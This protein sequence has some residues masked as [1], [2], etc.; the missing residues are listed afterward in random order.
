MNKCFKIFNS[1]AKKK[2]SL[3][4]RITS[5]MEVPLDCTYIVFATEDEYNNPEHRT[6]HEHFSNEG[7]YINKAERPYLALSGFP[8]R[9]RRKFN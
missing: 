5:E 4:K 6:L 3:I 7:F 2:E 9:K 8:N 1:E